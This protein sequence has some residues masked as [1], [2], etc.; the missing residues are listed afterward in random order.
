MEETPECWILLWEEGRV[1]KRFGETSVSVW[2]VACM[3]LMLGLVLAGCTAQKFQSGT[4]TLESLDEL[5]ITADLYIDHERTAPFILLCHRANWSRGEY[6]E[7]A[8]R[9]NEMGFNCMAIDQ[10]SGVEVNGVI[11][12]THAE[13]KELKRPRFYINALPDLEAALLHVR[14][15]WKIDKIIM[16]GSSYSASLAIAMGQ[17]YADDIDGVI[18]FSPGEYLTVNN[19]KIEEYAG[20]ITCPVFIAS[21]KD[22]YEKWASIY[23]RIPSTTKSYFLP[24]TNGRHGSEALW[25]KNEGYKEYWEA[26]ESFLRQFLQD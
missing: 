19:K 12:E 18:A 17:K 26:L 16:W 23:D 25:E 10:R 9:L 13:A 6:L 8:P 4:I 14:D 21:A 7:I 2:C 1:V 24:E 5:T 22:E 15:K 3:F 11:N 20:Q